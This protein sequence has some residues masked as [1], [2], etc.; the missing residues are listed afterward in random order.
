MKNCQDESSIETPGGVTTKLAVKQEGWSPLTG[1]RV[2][3]SALQAWDFYGQFR[4]GISQRTFLNYVGKKK[5]CTH[6]DD[7]KY[8]VEDIEQFSKSRGW[9]PSP[10]FMLM[11]RTDTTEGKL[12]KDY[13]ALF[14]KEKALTQ[15][16][17]RRGK[18]LDLARKEKKLIPRELYEQQLAAAAVIVCTGAESF[19]YENVR[20]IIQLAGGSLENEDAV[21]EFMLSKVNKF[22]H[23][24]YNVKGYEVELE[25][26]LDAE[27]EQQQP[28]DEEVEA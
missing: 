28:A 17:I 24:F 19:V 12:E 18:E 26:A 7:K 11:A 20:E 21:R 16:M 6:R 10:E 23:G 4:F 27:A 5:D 9:P 22:L 2:F 3:K 1:Q 8:Y 14:Q 13:G 25:Q 15:E